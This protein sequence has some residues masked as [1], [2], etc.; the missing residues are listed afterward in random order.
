M[1]AVLAKSYEILI[2]H[3]GRAIV[4]AYVL[5]VALS[6]AIVEAFRLGLFIKG[7]L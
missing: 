4:F 7:V 6:S 5:I 2:G 1:K 3:D